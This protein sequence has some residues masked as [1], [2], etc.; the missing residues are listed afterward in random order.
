M[1]TSNYIGIKI[2]PNIYQQSYFIGKV[3]SNTS[4]VAILYVGIGYY[5][6]TLLG[7]QV[8]INRNK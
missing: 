8:T 7:S 1:N 5:N 2:D 4:V 6:Y 3:I